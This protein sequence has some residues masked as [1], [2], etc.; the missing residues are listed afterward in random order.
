M[1]TT[2]FDSVFTLGATRIQVPVGA[3]LALYCKPQEGQLGWQLKYLSGGTCEI[4]PTGIGSSG[5]NLSFATTLSA[6]SLA[7][8]SGGGYL[9]GAVG[10]TGPGFESLNISGPAAFYLSSTGATAI[11][12]ALLLK[13]QGY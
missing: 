6:A 4:L 10:S 11:I 7:A 2:S 9:L 1:A 5:F 13:G 12:A 3:T 8:F